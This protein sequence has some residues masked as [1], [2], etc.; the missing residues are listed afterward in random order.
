MNIIDSFTGSYRFLSNFYP[1]KVRHGGINFPTV[2]HA[3]QA[4]KTIFAHERVQISNLDTPAAAK[5]AGRKL[6]IRKDWDKIKL[7]I[8][9]DLVE[10]KFSKHADLRAK[11]LKTGSAQL[12]EGNTWGDTYW[13]MCDGKGENN[14]G[15][16]LMQIREGIT[17]GTAD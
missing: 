16:I 12:V 14:L 9:R 2:E 5:A 17:D 6:K 7:N 10:K 8:M 13:G 1:A 15:K 4:A 11:L 3:Y